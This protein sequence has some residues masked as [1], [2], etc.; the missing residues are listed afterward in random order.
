MGQCVVLVQGS[1]LLS[2]A[3][4]CM[5]LNKWQ[6]LMGVVAVEE[7]G[8]ACIHTGISLCWVPAQPASFLV[9]VKLLVLEC[10]VWDT[11]LPASAAAA[12]SGL[13]RHMELAVC[14]W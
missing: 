11:E 12:A 14:H 13:S 9:L 5:F 8:V 3:V 10:A 6:L 2:F 1:R 7:P 4:G